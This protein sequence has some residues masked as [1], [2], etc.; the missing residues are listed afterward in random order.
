MAIKLN[1]TIKNQ[2]VEAAAEAKL[3]PIYEKAMNE[4]TVAARKWQ[5][6][7]SL[8]AEA[9]KCDPKLRNHIGAT[10]Y[11]HFEK[12]IHV[13]DDNLSMIVRSSG[14][15]YISGVR[16]DN[17]IYAPNGTCLPEDFPDYVKFKD[18][19]S[20]IEKT[21]YEIKQ[22]VHSYTKAEKMFEDLPWTKEFYPEQISTCTS[23]VAK[24]T[25]D[26]LNEV[27]GATAQA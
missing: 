9:M 23:L 25:I 5:V 24:E 21:Y 22:T 11:V 10:G 18:I 4:L 8:H 20:Q 3:K 6:G 16:L 27:M 15:N 2:I 7:H 26:K 17:P 14:S 13:R 1:K 19:V 12:S